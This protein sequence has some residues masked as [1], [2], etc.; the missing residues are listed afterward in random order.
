MK[1][2][3]V[4]LSLLCHLCT[5]AL[6]ARDT[7]WWGYWNTSMP[8]QA[9]AAVAAGSA[10]ETVCAIRLTTANTQFIDGAIHGVRFW[11]EDKTAVSRA[12]V[13]VSAKPFSGGTPDMAVSEIDIA[14][15][16]DRLHDGGPT[17]ARFDTPVDVLPSTN[18]YASVYVG[19]TIETA[20]GCQL[21]AAGPATRIGA[22]TCYVGWKDSESQYGPLALQIEVSGP[23]IADAG[24]TVQPLEETVAMAGQTLY[25]PCRLTNA[26]AAAV[27]S[28]DCEVAIDGVAQ[29]VQHIAFDTP[30]DELGLTTGQ[31]VHIAVP[32]VATAYDC[33]LSVTRVNGQTAADEGAQAATDTR[34]QNFTLIA[35]SRQPVKRTVMEELTGTWCPNCP[36]GL[37]GMELLEQQFADRFIGIAVHGGSSTEPMRVADYDGS[38]F[39]RGVSSRMGGRPSCSFDRMADG[40]PYWGIGNGPHFGAAQVVEWLLE[41]PCVADIEMEAAWSMSQ[42]DVIECDVYTTFRY[43]STST[44]G[45][46]QSPFAL[47]MVLTAD[48]LT[49]DTDEWLQVNTLAGRTDLD[50][51]LA[52]FTSGERRMRIKFNHVAIA[53]NGV[54]SGIGGSI[55]TPFR[56]S[57][58][59]HFHT[60]FD[61]AGN[62]LVQSRDNIHAIAMLIDTRSGYVVNA[63][64]CSVADGTLGIEEAQGSTG[65]KEGGVQRYDLLGRRA[66]HDDGRGLH[67]NTR[68]KKGLYILDDGRKRLF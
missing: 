11:L 56:D 1:K 30:I 33:R 35:L 44:Q 41:Q 18:R 53:V 23:N 3:I 13:W 31:T 12:C 47:I 34:S 27:E 25:M 8:L 38:A 4:I 45:D 29:T 22:N 16:K 43:S 40:D 21:M 15:L 49:G 24:M 32:A 7:V 28:I 59:Q 17:V 20:G 63:A 2:T 14:D 10:A 62:S 55:G 5:S 67:S 52:M 19:Y 48:S 9:T 57:E 66:T 68:G 42:P 51:D 37:V 65:R 50:D 58:P 61:M 26:G 46:L 36:R 39:V 54:E 64:K 6:L 60:A